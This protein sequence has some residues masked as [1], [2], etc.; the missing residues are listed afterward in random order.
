MGQIKQLNE[1]QKKA[2][3]A[4]SLVGE[5]FTQNGI[6][7][8]LLAGTTLGAVREKGMIAW[9]DD[10]DIGVFYED[11]EKVAE[12][13]SHN[14]PEE[15]K[16]IDRFSDKNYAKLHG[17][18]LYKD[19]C[20][21]DVFP[22]VKTTDNLF[23]R[24]VQWMER[25]ILSKTIKA[26]K[27]GSNYID[28]HSGKVLTEKAKVLFSN[29]F[30]VFFPLSFLERRVKKN[31]LRYQKGESSYYINMYSIYSLEKELIKKDWLTNPSFVE[32]EGRKYPT[33]SDTD[34]YLRKL[35]G[36]YMTPPPEKER[37]SH[38]DSVF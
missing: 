34:S 5:I 2:I 15:Y 20:V 28:K 21:I 32:F 27:P 16:W 8:F 38:H 18:I 36:D 17:K 19:S 9:D 33:V 31:A 12:L 37:Y 11:E 13:L 29:V 25:K 14:L 26:K 30:S 23:F 6:R 1:H 3:Y 10:I 35:Y 24:R 4:L 7:Y 22:L